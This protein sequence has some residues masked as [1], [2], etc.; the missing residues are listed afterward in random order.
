ML[1]AFCFARYRRNTAIA[2][3][4]SNVMAKCG[5][6][7]SS[8][9]AEVTKMVAD[10]IGEPSPAD[11]RET[12][13]D[14][15]KIAILNNSGMDATVRNKPRTC[16][17]KLAAIAPRIKQI[18]KGQPTEAVMEEMS[19]PVTREATMTAILVHTGNA[20][21]PFSA[22]L[23]TGC[24][25]VLTWDTVR[26]STLSFRQ[27]LNCRPNSCRRDQSHLRHHRK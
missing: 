24:D 16:T 5:K 3:H 27:I 9:Y 1:V 2:M 18:K 10:N 6:T 22:R 14:V 8:G 4:P 21:K 12:T 19:N 25:W 13:H 23:L 26:E 7:C 20:P 11:A 17:I 15:M